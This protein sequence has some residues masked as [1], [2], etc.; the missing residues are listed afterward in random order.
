VVPTDEMGRTFDAQ[1]S[2]TLVWWAVTRPTMGNR[3]PP[4]PQ[5]GATALVTTLFLPI[6]NGEAGELVSH[7]TYSAGKP[8]GNP[9]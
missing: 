2:A 7:R 6:P 4:T 8:T 9:P 1:T 3:V 5:S